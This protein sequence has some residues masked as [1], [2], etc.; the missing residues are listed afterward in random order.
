MSIPVPRLGLVIHYSFLWSTEH[1]AG[2]TEG[3]KDRPCAIVVAVRR[4]TSGDI[5]T[6]V[7]PVTQQPSDHPAAFIEI[8]VAARALPANAQWYP[9]PAKRGRDGSFPAIRIRALP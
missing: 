1:A 6:I 7:A 8:P 9:C 4:E 2:A 3:V 5:Q